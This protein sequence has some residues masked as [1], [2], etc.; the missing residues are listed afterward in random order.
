MFFNRTISIT[1]NKNWDCRYASYH[2]AGYRYAGYHYAGYHYAGYQYDGY[3]YAGYCYAGYHYA[4]CRQLSAQACH[5]LIY[6]VPILLNLGS[7][8]RMKT[9]ALQTWCQ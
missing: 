8:I 4:G 2:Y 9:A 1:L 6:E 5:H 7:I 3:H